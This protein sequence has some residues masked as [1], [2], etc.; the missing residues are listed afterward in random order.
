MEQ[1]QRTT[2]RRTLSSPPSSADLT[3]SMVPPNKPQNSSLSGSSAD[4]R[5]T[6]RARESQRRFRA[7][8]LHQQRTNNDGL[9]AGSA[10]VS[11][12]SEDLHA[13]GLFVAVR[14]SACPKKQFH[15]SIQDE[16]VPV[17]HARRGELHRL[18]AGVA[19][20]L[21]L[22]QP[23]WVLIAHHVLETRLDA[24][25]QVFDAAILE[26][27][28]EQ[29]LQRRS[30]G[31]RRGGTPVA[32]ICS[33]RQS[34]YR[35]VVLALAVL[36][37]TAPQLVVQLDGLVCRRASL[38]LAGLAAKPEVQVPCLGAARRCLRAENDVAI[39]RVKLA[40]ELL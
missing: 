34:T 20:T 15:A 36:G 21:D 30:R 38:V 24:A 17:V 13:T 18:H 8:S 22:H 32:P 31:E 23:C 2:E 9:W 28:E 40:V 11:D 35:F 6:Q 26:I 3:S 19:A 27:G 10:L 39:T 5:C 4:T 12:A 29:S 33:Q 7:G 1:W 14:F 25:F 37:G 16:H